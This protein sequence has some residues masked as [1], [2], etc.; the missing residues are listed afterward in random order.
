MK[1]Q[2]VLSGLLVLGAGTATAQQER[3]ALTL[4]Q[5]VQI[6]RERNPV[7]RRVQLGIR[8]AEARVLSAYGSF[9]PSLDAR[10]SWSGTR[11]TTSVGEDDFG[12][13]IVQD[14]PRP[15]PTA[16]AAVGSAGPPVDRGK[17]VRWR[18]PAVGSPD[19][20]QPGQRRQCSAANR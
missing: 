12:G 14:Q 11:R 9:L 5:A 3:P 4:E 20:A 8:E 13:T 1:V 18:N 15:F 17:R 16:T 6:A 7:F 19:P 2:V 10:M